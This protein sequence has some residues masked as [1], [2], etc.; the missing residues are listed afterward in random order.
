MSTETSSVFDI[1][2]SDDPVPGAEISATRKTDTV[3]TSTYLPHSVHEVLREIAYFERVKIH[4]LLIEGI[5]HVLKS[6]H[7][8]SVA[9]LKGSSGRKTEG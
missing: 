5:D 8:P 2:P 6:R 9:E 3:K 4:D 7:H 1:P